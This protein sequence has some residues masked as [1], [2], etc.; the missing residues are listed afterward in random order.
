M[1][2]G[3]E[4]TKIAGNALN[5]LAPVDDDGDDGDGNGEGEKQRTDNKSNDVNGFDDDEL[6][7]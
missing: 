4:A 7:L 6:L 5:A 1:S 3:L 2:E